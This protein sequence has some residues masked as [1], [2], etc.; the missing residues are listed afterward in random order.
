[1]ASELGCWGCSLSGDTCGFV[2]LFF[3]TLAFFATRAAAWL[4]FFGVG[5]FLVIIIVVFRRVS[6]FFEGSGG[7][8]SERPTGS[9]PL[10][11]AP[12]PL[13][14]LFVSAARYLSVADSP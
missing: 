11:P 12:L 2:E 9:L 5:A 10:S 14:T 13:A 7:V 6:S 1:M 4:I 3:A 8:S